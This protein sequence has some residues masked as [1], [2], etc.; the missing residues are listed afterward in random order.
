M[1]K[2]LL[3]IITPI[4]N[5]YHLMDRLLETLEKQTSDDFEVIFINDLSTDKTYELLNQRLKTVKFKYKLLTNSQN[6]GPGETRNHGVSASEGKYITF[7]DSDD[8]ISEDFVKKIKYEIEKNK[9]D[10]LIFDYYINSGNKLTYKNSLPLNNGIVD[11]TDALAL[12]NGM[13]WGKVFK[14]NIIQ[15]NKV[16]FPKLMR[17]EDLAFVKVAIFYSKKVIYLKEPLYFYNLVE[18]SIMHSRK[19]LNNLNNIKAYEYIEK[20]I[21][22]KRAL[23]MIFVRDY[24]YIIVQNMI[25]QKETNDRIKRFIEEAGKKFPEWYKNQYIKMQPKYLQIILKLIKHKQ[26]ICLKAIFR[27]KK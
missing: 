11:K 6:V 4:Y 19:T 14:K 22:D 5:C 25:L 24:L 16:V 9:L 27:L 10:V 20:N 15:E 1:N 17:S 12:C 23:E 2:P 13:C 26:M 18:T 7:I 3:S 21:S 8:Y